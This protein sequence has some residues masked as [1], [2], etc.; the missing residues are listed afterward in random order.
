MAIS[1]VTGDV[2]VG[3]NGIGNGQLPITLTNI[4]PISGNLLVLDVTVN[5]TSVDWSVV[6]AAGWTKA[7]D[8]TTGAVLTAQFYKISD[9]TETGINVDIGSGRIIA[10]IRQFTG[11]ATSSVLDAAGYENAYASSGTVKT[12]PTGSATSTVDGAA[13]ASVGWRDGRFVNGGGAHTASNSFSFNASLDPAIVL[14]QDAAPWLDLLFL[15]YTGAASRTSTVTQFDSDEENAG[16]IGLYKAAAAGY[17]HPTLSNARMGSITTT[18][19]IPL[20]DYTF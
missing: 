7:V 11:N 6:T 4:V 15:A 20:V 5:N 16:V 19:G 17:T 9:G 14:A 8:S 13:I 10:A 1:L 3:G 18:G 2:D 12:G